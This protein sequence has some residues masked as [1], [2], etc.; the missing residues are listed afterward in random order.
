VSDDRRQR[1][2]S[3]DTLPERLW[4]RAEAYGFG[5][6]IELVTSVA[7]AA[8]CLPYLFDGLHEAATFSLWID[9]ITSV[10]SYSGRGPW[11]TVT[12]YREANNHI[13]FNLLNSITPGAGSFDPLHARLWS[14]IAVL[15]T[16]ALVGFELGRRRW[17]LAA[18][19]FM[20]VVTINHDLL[21]LSLQARGYGILLFCATAAGLWVMRFVETRR[22]RWLVALAVIVV[23][24]T[25]TVPTFV[26]FGGAVW[27][28]L[29]V[30]D[31]SARVLRYGAATLG[32]IVLA[33][34]PV[35]QQLRSQE[36]TY[37]Q[38][39]GRSYDRIS[40]VWETIH[41]YLPLH[42][43]GVFAVV[44][45]VVIGAAVALAR[46]SLLDARRWVPASSWVLLGACA[47][48]FAG[49]RILQTPLVRTTAFVVAPLALALLAPAAELIRRPGF[50]V[51]RPT[52]AITAA[53]LLVPT[54]LAYGKDHKFVPVEQWK[55][56]GAY[57][58]TTFPDG[59]PV[60]NQRTP[61]AVSAYLSHRDRLTRTFD[62]DALRDGRLVVVDLRELKAP[63]SSE[64]ATATIMPS[65][66]A[67]LF[68]EQRGR[69]PAHSMS[70]LFAP[71]GNGHVTRATVN[72]ESRPALIDGNLSTAFQWPGKSPQPVTFDL[73]A[74]PGTIGRS[75]VIA[76]LVRLP[77][78]A[79][80]VTT[81]SPSGVRHT[82]GTGQV[83]YS[84]GLFTARLGDTEV[85]HVEVTVA[86]PAAATP[87]TVRDIWLYTP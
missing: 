54:G 17:F 59:T 62:V 67:Q 65:L 37:A 18:A 76:G 14:I 44:A 7:I 12:T 74:A 34:L 71:P 84:N 41:T 4:Q 45:F 35:Q 80:T 11:T 70:V 27:L 46:P 26:F 3:W 56:A 40:D 31:R 43:P 39:F 63:D 73:T 81:V 82:V 42:L 47:G 15:A 1:S 25:W 36:A 13:F 20:F 52:A 33:Y 69:V 19:L 2:S 68:T 85:A 48:F 8:A 32:A 10:S 38:Q 28:G 49:C 66:V 55:S 58:A 23:V 79:M 61:G 60:Y 16:L 50:E 29:L 21:E 57:V 5:D 53:L 64:V 75:L 6:L 22:R 24:G 78:K 9:E 86:M 30:W 87:F 77:F 83:T 72:G 51:I